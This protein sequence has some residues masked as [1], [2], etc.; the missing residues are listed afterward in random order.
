[1]PNAMAYRLVG[2]PDGAREFVYVSQTVE[3]LHEVSAADVLSDASI[4]YDQILPEQ[5]PGLEA[6][7]RESMENRGPFRYEVACRLPSGRVRWFEL[8]SIPILLPDGRTAWEGLE[9]D[10]TP[11]CQSEQA[12]RA[13]EQRFRAFFNTSGVG[14]AQSDV[15]TNQLVDVN[16]EFC[17]ISGYARGELIGRPMEELTHPDDRAAEQAQL[18]RLLAGE[19][20]CYTIE[21]RMIRPDGEVVW[22]RLTSSLT[23]PPDRPGVWRIGILQ[24]VTHEK[25]AADELRRHEERFRSLVQATAAI[26]WETP[27][28]GLLET[29]QPAWRDFTGQTWD[30]MKGAGW[31]N[32]VHPEDRER[33][34]Q[35]WSQALANRQPYLFEYRLR[36]HDGVYHQ[37]LARGVPIVDATGEVREWIGTC[38]D[39]EQLRL[40]E[41]AVRES[42]ELFR[43]LADNIAQLAWMADE[44]GSIFW[45][46]KRWYDYTGMTLDEAQGWG[47]Q[48]V[49]H[50]DHVHR[51]LEKF[52]SCLETGTAWEDTFPLRGRNGEYRWFLAQAIPI[53]DA[54]GKVVRWLGTNT[55]VTEQRETERRLRESRALYRNRLA[56]LQTIYASAPIGLCVLD[57]ES[58]FVRI[59]DRLA[60]VNG[61]SAAEHIGRT[62]REVVPGLAD[63]HEPILREVIERGQ[64]VVDREISGE[65][66]AMPG[67]TRHWM[68]N[69]FPLLNEAGE[70]TGVNVTAQEITDRKHT[71]QA[72]QELLEAEQAARAE[73]ERYNRLKDEFLATV[74][75]ELRNPLN[76]I[77]GWTRLLIEGK[78]E[79]KRA[80]QIVERNAASLAQI[81]SDLLDMSRI[82]SG[83]IHLQRSHADLGPLARSV[84]ESVQLSAQA[85]N[86]SLNSWIDPRLR[87][88]VCDPSRIQQII[89][90]LLTNAIKFTPGG[91]QVWLRVA[92][93][94]SQ[95]HISVR[96]TGQG[97]S[98]EFLPNV[99]GR[100]LQADASTTRKH[101]GLGLGL[102]ITKQ[103]V[104]L[105]GGTIEAFSEGENKGAVFTVTLPCPPGEVSEAGYADMQSHIP[106]GRGAE[107]PESILAGLTVLVIDDDPDSCELTG[108]LLREAGAQVHTAHSAEEGFSMLMEIRP[109]VL[110]SD[111]SM[112]QQDGLE[113]IRKIRSCGGWCTELACIALTALA[114]PQD[115]D[116]VLQAGYD[117]YITKPFDA[118]ALPTLVSAM[119]SRSGRASTGTGGAEEPAARTPETKV[120]ATDQRRDESASR[121][122]LLVEDNQ[123]VCE[124]LRMFLEGSG[125]RVSTAATVRDALDIAR[126]KPIDVLLSDFRL[127]DGTGW[128]LMREL[129]PIQQVPGVMLSGYSDKIYV[130]RSKAAGFCRYLVKPVDEEQLLEAVASAISA[131]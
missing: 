108:R 128:D 125:Y 59:N 58:R 19:I 98:P 123:P 111:I 107:A 70:V 24:D 66:P 25:Q 115:R 47:W 121:H 116:R 76:A 127:A 22:V 12:L 13:S 71:E 50:P 122:V 117:E 80:L 17:R 40:A 36:R 3:T 97:I 88:I 23:G 77:L 113:L 7:E 20:P 78:A 16:E 119:S 92:Q 11:R 4:L 46:N 35:A 75:H 53:R 14:M 5:R 43:T 10:I 60:E 105:H 67:V 41:Q 102:A 29:D 114:R 96:D 72:R 55:D 100:F 120:A 74:S 95:I 86:I 30:E 52:R 130:D 62:V 90:N 31:L 112:P 87:P 69:Y 110:L 84:L 131:R 124:M 2:R 54:E 8:H 6:A 109:D 56:E 63:Q 81:V 26:V 21:K 61:L 51:V 93:E 18:Q 79:T 27:A 34:A 101:G 104:E 48:A 1:M 64:P 38:T 129:R 82:I 37:V 33:T 99:F 85:K 9:I 106:A 126:S 83:K 91:G 49:H 57:R 32:A 65:T 15:T 118:S 42:G 68:I 44:K 103:L 73:L 89:W 28:S 45:F 94:H 39:I